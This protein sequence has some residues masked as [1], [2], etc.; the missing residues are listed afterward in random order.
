VNNHTGEA[1]PPRGTPLE[2]VERPFTTDALRL[3]CFLS[4]SLDCGFG[5]QA[6][7]NPFLDNLKTAIAESRRNLAVSLGN[8]RAR[9]AAG[10]TGC[11]HEDM[12]GTNL[13]KMHVR[14]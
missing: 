5:G 7:E 3:K 6:P 1:V 13:A 9:I 8:G 4:G 14:T 11:D 2:I 12:V 10:F